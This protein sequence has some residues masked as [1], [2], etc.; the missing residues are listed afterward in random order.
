MRETAVGNQWLRIGGVW[1][2]PALDGEVLPGIG[3]ARLLAVARRRG[4][5]VAERTCDL[6][7]LHRAEALAQSNAVFGPRP[8]ALLGAALPGVAFVDDELVP[9]WRR[10]ADD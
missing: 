2:T 3:R 4:L 1:V 9:L 8:A 7:D 5:P 10:A 6:G